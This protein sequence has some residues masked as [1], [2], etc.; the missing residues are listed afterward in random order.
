MNRIESVVVSGGFDPIHVGHLRMFKDASELA[1]R[2]IVVI[3]NDHFL[4]QK[5]TFLCQSRKEWR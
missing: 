2:L 3:N 5:V 1:P 4:M